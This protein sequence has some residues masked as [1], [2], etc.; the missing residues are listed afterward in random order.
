MSFNFSSTIKDIQNNMIAS[1]IKEV[2]NLELLKSEE[3][4]KAVIG[5]YTERFKTVEGMLTD[6]VHYVAK[7]ETVVKLSDFNNFF[8]SIYI[9]LYALYNDL[10][11]VDSV[12]TL[13]VN[14]NKNYFLVIKKRVRELWQRLEL[15]RLQVYDMSPSD[16]SYYESFCSAINS[17]FVSNIKVDKKNGFITL[18][19][20]R[21][22]LLNSVPYIKSVTSKTYPVENENGGVLFTTS[23]LNDLN[24][25][26]TTGTRDLLSDG[27]W[28][29]E[30]LCKDIPDMILNIGSDNKPIFR[31]YKGIVSIIDI[32]YSYPVDL[33]R[34]DID[35]FGEKI[36]DIDCILY[37][38]IEEDSDWVPAIYEADDPMKENNPLLNLRHN[39]ISDRAFD[40]IAFLNIQKISVKYLRIVFNQQNYSLLDS[41]S[42]PE[43]TLEQQI[44]LDLSERRYELIKFGSSLDE[45][46]SS[47]VNDDNRSLYS[48][49]I[50][51]IESTR[52]IEEIL[53]RINVLL[54]PQLKTISTD[55]SKT[56]SFELGAW[57][58]EPMIE[59]YTRLQGK[60][61][62]KLYN[63]NDKN[64][65]SAQLKTA[66]N[67]PGATTCNWY[68][69]VNDVNLPIHENELTWRKEPFNTIP[70]NQF[71]S[72]STWPGTFVLLDF[73]IDLSRSNEIGIYENGIFNYSFSTK[74]AFLNSRLLYL[75]NL[76]DPFRADYVI[77]Y[78]LAKY[79]TVSTY[80]LNYKNTSSIYP[81]SAGIVS[82]RRSVLEKFAELAIDPTSLNKDT[83]SQNY[84]ISNALAT[85]EEAK[86]WFGYN[87]AACIFIDDAISSLLDLST[88]GV[89][90][91]IISYGITKLSTSLSD[92]DLYSQGNGAGS[93]DLGPLSIYSNVVPLSF[94]RI[95]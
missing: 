11:A 46:I 27:L 42:L 64:L 56:A 35:I 26:Y 2:S 75:H 24:T 1:S 18:D 54:V 39:S 86:M 31:N 63:I 45:D 78:P 4:I 70:S 20:K 23:P 40:V 37:K 59:E 25:N 14:R 80:V 32:E 67:A 50:S 53:S 60:Y 43:R 61:D 44:E 73:P 28:K 82:S 8:E 49:I 10:N 58:I 62:S 92:L 65:I 30:V 51:I 7:S 6:I 72:F 29:E 55:F 48:K 91:E 84:T 21:R 15:T 95:L 22:R 9:D 34:I 38:T 71:S 17:T 16:E 66:Q 81:I 85:T 13:N 94:R 87:Y 47:P 5:S 33:N 68:I 52:N 83:L 19:T 74:I 93:S 79:N 69:S 76:T 41:N 88:I 77:R 89:L 90:S 12:L 3:A 36:L 57:S